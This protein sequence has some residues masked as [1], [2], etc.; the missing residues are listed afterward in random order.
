VII[1]HK[2]SRYTF[3]VR[4]L[5]TTRI[6]VIYYSQSGDAAR[7]AG[8]LAESLRV[9]GVE[10]VVERIVPRHAYPFP[11]RSVRRFFDVLPECMIGPAPDIIPPAFNPDDDFQLVILVYQVWFLCPSL[12]IQGFLKSDA[13][14]VLRGTKVMTVSVSRD[15]W[16]SASETMKKLL[17]AAGAIH[18]DNAAVTHQGPTWATFITAPRFLLFGKAGPFLGWLPPAG[19]REEDIAGMSRFGKAITDRL[20]D[21]RDPSCG[22]L[23][24]GH[25]PVR[26]K[27]RFLLPELVGWYWFR[28]WAYGLR[29]LGR[30]GHWLRSIGIYLF[31]VFLVVG[32]VMGIPILILLRLILAPFI[33]RHLSS[34]AER[35]AQPSGV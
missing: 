33:S 34:Y 1:G 24:A 10:V 23:L 16:Q 6:L 28:A 13:A 8:S 3:V 22:P 31:I 5:S 4:S 14:R 35:L 25:Q 7:I 17:K 9:P 18:I 30:C 11:W 29:F 21:L 12:P 2:K 19:V 27:Q 26:I 15:M 20:G 32:V